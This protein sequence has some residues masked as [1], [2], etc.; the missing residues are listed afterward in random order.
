MIGVT[1]SS[2]WTLIE[3]LGSG[4]FGSVYLA[5]HKTSTTVAACKLESSNHNL[6][7]YEAKIYKILQGK[8]RSIPRFF[9]YGYHH[10]YPFM[11][12]E[13]LD[14]SLEALK[15]ES[16]G[17][18]CTKDILMIGMQT[19]ES[20]KYFHRSYF[21][22]RDIKAENFM[23][24]C[25]ERANIIY[26]IDYGLAKNYKNPQTRQHISLKTNKSLTGTPRFA[27]IHNHQGMEQS[28]RDDLESLAYV[29]IYLAKG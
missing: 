23:I 28:R 5:R 11:I 4:S 13:R 20:L 9:E 21:I 10:P 25:Q 1:L 12:C 16:G 22:H 8:H 14:R 3:K 15:Q 19:I 2:K 7:P 24:G 18:L 6:L 17:T 26:L 27:S 29:L